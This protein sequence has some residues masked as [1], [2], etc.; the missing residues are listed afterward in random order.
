[1][2]IDWRA[3]YLR[4]LDGRRRG[5]LD[6]EVVRRDGLPLERRLTETDLREA[7]G[8]LGISF[9][10]EYREHLLRQ[11]NPGR[12]CK[13]PW[14]G[15]RGWGWYGDTH[16]NYDLLT[17]PFPH[18]DSYRAYDA[19]LDEREPPREDAEAWEEW[20]CEG[21]VLEE[22]K[23]AGAVYIQEGG[24][25][26]STLLV[27]TGPHRGEMW[28]DGRATCDRILPLRWAGRPVS[29]AEWVERGMSLTPW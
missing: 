20:D 18:P 16:T 4:L 6:P 2:K 5:F 14:R 9:P 13:P 29:F 12:G 3:E 1:M 10:V 19:E 23:T 25:G 27:V 22:R 26:F 21:G 7:E 17:E 28:F 24:C 15:P 11:G 8:E